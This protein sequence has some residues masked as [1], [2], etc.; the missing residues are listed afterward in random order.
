[1]DLRVLERHEDAVLIRVECPAE[2]APN[3]DEFLATLGFPAL[4]D[5]R[6]GGIMVEGGLRI[7][8]SG[9]LIDGAL[10][11]EDLAPSDWWPT[12][13]IFTERGRRTLDTPDEPHPFRVSRATSRI[14]KSGHPWILID[15]ETDDP[16]AYAPGTRVRV[17]DDVGATI[18]DAL[19]DWS[20]PIAGRMWSNAAFPPSRLGALHDR[21]EAALA[22][23]EKVLAPLI[24]S[25]KTTAYRLIHGE[26]DGL[27]GLFVD[28]L[29]PGLR[30][31]VQAYSALDLVDPVVD[32]IVH[33]L[34]DLDPARTPVIRVI[35]LRPKPPGQ[36]AGVCL[37][38]GELPTQGAY[39]PGR[40]EVLERGQRFLVDVGLRHAQRPTTA[41][42]SIDSQRAEGAG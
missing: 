10:F 24:Q 12:E 34:V 42:A 35:H 41:T 17:T 3:F 11:G 22:R 23:R 8:C 4:G 26:A 9:A 19:I 39:E 29:G 40:W 31:L 38:R 1:M 5:P 14:L 33:H 6:N 25:G 7:H 15:D 16:R 36:L 13:A 21:V 30:V 37:I 27:P 2:F 32:Q 18:G 28:R 20:S